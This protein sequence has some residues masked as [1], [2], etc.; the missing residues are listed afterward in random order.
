[1]LNSNMVMTRNTMHSVFKTSFQLI[2][3]LVFF[4][5]YNYKVVL[6]INI[7]FQNGAE[8]QAFSHFSCYVRKHHST[9][10]SI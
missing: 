9:H 10:N 5:K 4:V 3:E 6:I 1:M 7:H 8:A 2:N